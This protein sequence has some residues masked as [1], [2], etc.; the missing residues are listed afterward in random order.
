MRY[1]LSNDKFKSQLKNL[2]ERDFRLIL[3]QL[4]EKLNFKEVD[5]NH[6]VTELGKDIVFYEEDKF[7]TKV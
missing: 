7:G 1:E 4:F 6:G 3:I 2:N 5:H